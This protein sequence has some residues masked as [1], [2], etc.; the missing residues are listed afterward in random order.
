MILVKWKWRI[1]L[2]SAYFVINRTCP[3]FVLYTLFF[4]F[5]SFLFFCCCFFFF[6]LF[7]FIS[8]CHHFHL[9]KFAPNVNCH[10]FSLTLFSFSFVQI[11][12]KCYLPF[13]SFLLSLF[14]FYDHFQRAFLL[15]LLTVHA[16]LCTTEVMICLTKWLCVS[17][18]AT[19]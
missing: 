5:F 11:C 15:I 1:C 18:T 17:S 16:K 13:F 12:T 14:S 8:H 7:S 2:I 3:V 6:F 4:L 9:C 10:F 19:I